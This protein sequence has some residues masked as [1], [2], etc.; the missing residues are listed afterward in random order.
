MGNGGV[1]VGNGGVVA[2]NGGVAAG[3]GGVV[4]AGLAGSGPSVVASG[5]GRAARRRATKWAAR[6]K[7]LRVA[8]S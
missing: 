6:L 4:A 2:G 3:N 5:F 1:V 7:V 8:L